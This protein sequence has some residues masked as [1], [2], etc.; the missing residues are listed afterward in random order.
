MS[1]V[2]SAFVL[3]VSGSN[4]GVDVFIGTMSAF[5]QSC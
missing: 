2:T 5:F 4:V 1:T 3:I